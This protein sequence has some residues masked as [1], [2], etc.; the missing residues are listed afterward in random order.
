MVQQNRNGNPGVGAAN[1]VSSLRARLTAGFPVSSISNQM[2]E[3]ISRGRQNSREKFLLGI[4]G[5][6]GSGKSTLAS[7]IVTEWNRLH[8]GQ[9]VLL[10]MD[11]YHL[12][13]EVLEERGLLPLKGIPETF[14]S[15][16]F[17]QKLFEIRKAP[18]SCHRCPRFDRSMEAS[19]QDAIEIS[20]AHKLVVIE[21]NYLLL[22]TAP[23]DKIAGLLDEIWFIDAEE[24]LIYPRLLARHMKGGK[25]KEAAA[26]KVN[27]TDLPNAR[28]VEKD[29]CRASR[30]FQASE[31][32]LRPA[33]ENTGKEAL[34]LPEQES[35]R[36]HH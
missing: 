23:W 24:A 13:N 10:P 28:L 9:A 11:G 18:L 15:H 19:I 30:I 4:C 16:S 31:L 29:R 25:N 2:I 5:A 32:N 21:G 6:P 33:R 22:D 7:W 36:T 27:S 20:P 1:M 34:D 14:D 26:E 17:V 12:S 35:R 3:L 8:S